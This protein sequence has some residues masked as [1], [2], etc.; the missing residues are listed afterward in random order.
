MKFF[1]IFGVI[2]SLFLELNAMVPVDKKD[3]TTVISSKV[4]AGDLKQPISKHTS[5][6]IPIFVV[7]ILSNPPIE[8]V[9]LSTTYRRLILDGFFVSPVLSMTSGSFYKGIEV[10]SPLFLVAN[11]D[12]ISFFET[13][14]HAFKPNK[15][16]HFYDVIPQDFLET[17]FHCLMRRE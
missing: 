12:D 6:E 5:I 2:F 15:C 9:K 3:D 8:I 13:I 17:K 4:E 14:V 7:Q 10:K 1:M 16:V 11:M